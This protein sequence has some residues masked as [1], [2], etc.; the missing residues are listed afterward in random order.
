MFMKTTIID[1]ILFLDPET[2]EEEKALSHLLY[3][4]EDS[5]QCIRISWEKGPCKFEFGSC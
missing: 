5:N 1:D 2:A 4:F 3:I